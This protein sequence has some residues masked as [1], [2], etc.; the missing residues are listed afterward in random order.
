M[1][2]LTLTPFYP[3]AEDNASGCFIAESVGELVQQGITSSVIA[4]HPMHRPRPGCDPKFP[5]VTWKKYF[6]LPG[7]PGLSSAGRFLHAALKS[8]V[9]QVHTQQPLS[10]IHAHAALPCGQAAMLLAR[11]LGIPFVVTVHGLDAYSSRQVP[12]WFGR[13]CAEACADVYGAAGRVI[14]ISEQVARRVRERV[15]DTASIS[16][17]YNGVDPSLFSPA[18]SPGPSPGF[19]G[20]SD[21]ASESVVI[22]S[23][24]N[25]IPI[26]GHEFLLR[27]VAAVAANH[28]QVQCKI[29]GDG[30]ERARLQQLARELGIEDRV[31]FLG[32]RPRSEVADAM[33]ECA[34]FALPSWYEGLGCVYLEAMS[35]QRPTIGCR[36][37]GIEEVIRHREN[38]WLTE[39]KD[40]SSLTAALQALL[41]DQPLREKLGRNGRQTI[42]QDYTLAH[43]AGRLLSI[44][45]ECLV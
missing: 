18:F 9:Q 25:L 28:P 36:G 43:Q 35:A 37:Q 34:L 8:R 7:N 30:A 10:L 45:Q 23:V 16:V 24:G 42:L 26:K 22:L 11:D 38:G 13:R 3:T 6:S 41:S 2:I 20:K 4:V 21:S 33:R 19:N 17:V 12:G 29:I 1:H 39:P 15:G 5:P 31:H 27:S 32:R 40:L 14:C 44:Y